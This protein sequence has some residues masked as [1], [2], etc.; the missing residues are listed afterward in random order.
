MPSSAWR[1]AARD[2]GTATAY[3]KSFVANT[4]IFV[5]QNSEE[6]IIIPVDYHGWMSIGLVVENIIQDSE[7]KTMMTSK[8]AREITG[9]IGF[10]KKTGMSFGLPAVTACNV[11]AQLAQVAGS[12]CSGCYACSGKYGI[13]NVRACQN[14]R[15]NAVQQLHVQ[16]FAERWVEAMVLLI[17]R[18]NET[19]KLEKDYFRWHDSGDL[20]SPAHLKAIISVAKKLPTIKFWLPTKEVGLVK[21]CIAYGC[22][23]PS[24]LCIRLSSYMIGIENKFNMDGK[25][26]PVSNVH[27]DKP[28]GFACPAIEAHSGCAQLGCRRCWSK[29]TKRVSYGQHR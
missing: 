16:N 12:V 11:G 3:T 17:S 27:T 28:L 8:Q 1:A 15:Y 4:N 5:L 19:L 21:D 7:E 10:T 9:D 6:K 24:N 20:I 25:D 18:K 23:I 14:V 26:F 13:P 2:P 29:R 22:K